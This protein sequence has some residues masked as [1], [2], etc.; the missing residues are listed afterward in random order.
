MIST[1]ELFD[2]RNQVALVTGAAMGIG[3]Q[4]AERLA[5][6]GAAVAIADIEADAAERTA[7]RIAG[8]TKGICRS[9]ACDVGRVSDVRSTVESVAK[10]LGRVD[11]VVNN[12]GIFPSAPALDVSEGMW[13]RVFSV[14]LKGAFFLAQAAAHQML[15]QGDGGT[16][17]NI[18][19][20]DAL[21]PTGR[22]APYDAS[23]AGMLMMTR[24]LAFELAPRRIRVN[25]IAPGAV[26]TPGVETSLRAMSGGASSSQM[27]NQFVSRIPLGRM[28]EPD[29]I[30]SAALF[31]ASRASEYVTGATLVVDGGYLL[32]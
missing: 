9:F 1:S 12:A 21:H 24:S 16:I 15:R 6:A 27:I 7:S 28:G 26:Q 32:T 22:L 3:A 29:D 30:A 11:I 31:F 2:L 5:R 8:S 19:S 14:N 25:A 18:A 23:K 10:S 13:D 4:I 17:I 20:I